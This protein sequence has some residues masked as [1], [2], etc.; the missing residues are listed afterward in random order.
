MYFEVIIYESPLACHLMIG[1]YD[2]NKSGSIDIGEFQQ[3]FQS[4]NQWKAIFQSYDKDFSG[5]ICFNE[6]SQAFQQMGYRF[7]PNF[8]NNL[9]G[10]YDPITKMLTLDNFIVVMV[11]IKRLTQVFR[12][13]DQ[14]MRGTATFQYE[15]F[16]GVAI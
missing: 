8:I 9:L 3:L 7:T 4:M 16:L 12:A 1:L 15:E 5:K 2:H 14:Q 6:L 10:K 11:Q 13:R